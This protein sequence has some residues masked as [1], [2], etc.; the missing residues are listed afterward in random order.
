MRVY[1]L[2]DAPYPVSGRPRYDWPLTIPLGNGKYLK[3]GKSAEVPDRVARRLGKTFGLAVSVGDVPEW[4]TSSKPK[5]T[6][7]TKKKKTS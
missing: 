7:K 6:P 5:S 3:P 1:N 2:T 4:H